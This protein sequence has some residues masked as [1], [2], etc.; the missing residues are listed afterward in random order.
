MLGRRSGVTRSDYRSCSRDSHCER[1]LGAPHNCNIKFTCHLRG[2]PKVLLAI[3]SVQCRSIA[4]R[5]SSASRLNPC[6]L[7]NCAPCRADGCIRAQQ[8]SMMMTSYFSASD[9][10]GINSVP[11]RVASKVILKHKNRT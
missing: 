10:N 9:K 2:M 11:E 7:R 4:W 5:R 6:P 1:A 3:G 8:R